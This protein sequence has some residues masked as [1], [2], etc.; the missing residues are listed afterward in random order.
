MRE[1]IGVCLARTQLGGARALLYSTG[2]GAE[3]NRSASAILQCE[4]IALLRQRQPR[5]RPPADNLSDSA[6][7]LERQIVLVAHDEPVRPA[8]VCRSILAVLIVGVI[9][10]RSAKPDV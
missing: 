4:R 9:D 3:I 8:V 1:N 2:I 6:V 7:R 5:N 10:V